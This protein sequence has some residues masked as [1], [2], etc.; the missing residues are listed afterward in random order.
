MTTRV[1]FVHTAPAL[2]PVFE[3]LL[4][5]YSGEVG[6]EALHVADAW[7]LRTAMATGVNP[8]VHA[9]VRA[10]V[11]HLAALGADAVLITCSS[12]GETIDSAA[13]HVSVPV[14]R[15]D[16]AMAQQARALAAGGTHHRIAALATFEST[17][18]PTRRLLEAAAGPGVEVTAEVVAGAAD[19]KAAGDI[20]GH[21]SAIRAAARRLAAAADV[22]VVAQASMAS[23][24][25]D[26]D[27][28]V[29]V[30]TSPR[31]GVEA[32][33]AAAR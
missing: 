23:A 12:I 2:T 18:G 6:A 20:A 26:A 19:A 15:V 1:G 5:E 8:G 29:P 10:H 14:L 21:D 30:L 32:V 11:E 24:V 7:L 3:D 25:A 31:T 13:A 28:P 16:A 4:A 17:L 33:L 27:L 9:R 22:I